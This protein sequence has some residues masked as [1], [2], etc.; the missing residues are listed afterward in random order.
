M[1]KSIKR[2]KRVEIQPIA[3]GVNA[4]EEACRKKPTAVD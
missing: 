1:K 3:V 4:G 2:R